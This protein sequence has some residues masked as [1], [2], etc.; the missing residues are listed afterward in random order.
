MGFLIELG[1]GD[2]LLQVLLFHLEAIQ[3]FLERL[4]DSVFG[5][6]RLLGGTAVLLILG[7]LADGRVP[8]AKSRAIFIDVLVVILVGVHAQREIHHHVD[9]VIDLR[10]KLG[11]LL[12]QVLALEGVGGHPQGLFQFRAFRRII[13]RRLF[14]PLDDVTLNA[15]HFR[16]RVLAVR[17]GFEHRQDSAHIGIERFVQLLDLAD[18]PR[19][20]LFPTS[21]VAGH[22]GDITLH[23]LPGWLRCLSGSLRPQIGK[24]QGHPK[25]GWI[26]NGFHGSVPQDC[27]NA[28]PKAISNHRRGF[29]LR[30]A[31]ERLSHSCLKSIAVF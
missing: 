31:A 12:H 15:R 11:A 22:F 9:H 21:D 1:V 4:T 29:G 24:E 2:L 23:L 17:A 30:F 7:V 20:A 6:A 8:A 14:D 3:G 18:D 19:R 26:K 5:S 27:D 25:D 10:V 28:P 16:L 13:L